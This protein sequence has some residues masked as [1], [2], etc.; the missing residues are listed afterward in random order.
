MPLNVVSLPQSQ[1]PAAHLVGICGS[2]MKSLAALLLDLGWSISG[3]DLNP[4]ESCLEW[5]RTRGIEARTGHASENVP[6]GTELVI[7][8][9]AVPAQNPERVAAR[10]GVFPSGR[11]ARCWVN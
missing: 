1:C 11:T 6:R 5:L 3:S 9:A 8:S 10:A 7:Y 4:S 2:G